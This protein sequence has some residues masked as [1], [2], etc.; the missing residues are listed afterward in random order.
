MPAYLFSNQLDFTDALEVLLQSRN[1]SQTDIAPQVK[2]M[3][4]AVKEQGDAALFDYTQRYDRLSLDAQ[5][6]RVSA[7][8]IEAAA[9]QCDTALLDALKLAAERIRDY[10]ERQ[11]PEDALYEDEL[12][13]KLGWRWR[14]VPRVGLYVPGG[15]AAY[16]S[17]VLMNAIPALAAGVQQ[18]VMVV[19]APKGKLNPVVLA[20]A[21]IAGI[22][23]I[24]RIGGAQ[25]VAALAFGTESVPKVDKIVGPGNQWVAEAK[26]QLY[27]T[28]GIDMIAGPSEICVVADAE[29]DPSWIA[30]DLLS[31]AEH[32]QQAQSILITDNERFASAVQA[33]LEAI[34][35]QLPREAIARESWGAY[36]AVILVEDICQCGPI[37][38]RI[39]PEHIE[40]LVKESQKLVDEIQCAGAIFIGKY[41]S[42]AL[43]D[44][45]AGPSHVLPTMSTARFSSGLSVYDFLNKQSVIHASAA[46]AKAIG[47]AA[48]RIAEAEG[49]GAHALSVQKR[50]D[51]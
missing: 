47:L 7:A 19:P 41:S 8:E 32:D 18:M 51:G 27:G 4:A 33:E 20:A 48:V 11:K 6:I 23:E 10:H 12:G 24:Y 49:L 50:L 21:K 34:L 13:N 44:Y 14:P 28:V 16:P 40:I 25:A 30:A 38:D 31:Q 15:K 35:K 3:I 45:V 5:S 29:N 42:E 37:I 22:E 2:E 39:A 46:G 1:S 36:G 26:R 17:S 9:S 43:G